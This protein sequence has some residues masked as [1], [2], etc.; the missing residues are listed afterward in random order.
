MVKIGHYST[1]NEEKLSNLARTIVSTVFIN[2]VPD[3]CFGCRCSRLDDALE[4]NGGPVQKALGYFALV[5]V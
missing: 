4:R 5:F 1:S 2:R 3:Q